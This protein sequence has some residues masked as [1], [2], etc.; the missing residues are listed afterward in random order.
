MAEVD[1]VLRG[2]QAAN[3][4]AWT[5]GMRLSASLEVTPEGAAFR[6]RSFTQLTPG[7]G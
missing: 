6:A 5:A 1:V 4:L 7:S 3:D 2:R